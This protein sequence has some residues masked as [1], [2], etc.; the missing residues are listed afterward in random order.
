VRARCL[1]CA[2]AGDLFRVRKERVFENDLDNGSAGDGSGD[3]S[4]VRLHL[5]DEA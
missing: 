3:R 2:A 4:D 5:L 1:D